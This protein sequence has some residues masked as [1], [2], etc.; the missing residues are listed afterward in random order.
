MPVVVVTDS[1]AC[2]PQESADACGI[3]VVPLHVLRDG[4][5]LREGVD[6]MPSDLSGVTTAGASPAELS[7]AY[8]RALDMSD[9]DGVL[10]VHISRQLSGTWEAG[11]VA[12]QEFGGAVR[13]VDSQSAGMGLGYPALEAAR[14]AEKGASLEEAYGRAVDVASRGRCYIVVDKLDQLRRGGRIGTAAALLGTAL[15][16]KPILHLVDGKLVLGEKTRTTTKALARLV[17]SAVER[18]G[19]GRVAIAVH[20]MRARERADAIAEQLAERIPDVAESVVTDFSA[21]I[22]AHVGVGAIGVVVCPL[23]EIDPSA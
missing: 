11:R 21:V 23:P 20:H 3:Q 15:A 12:A 7:E 10:A 16:M 9:G 22:G 19:L 6:A 2:I 8:A 13:I 14:L 1:S 18:A 17:D 5:D 4:C